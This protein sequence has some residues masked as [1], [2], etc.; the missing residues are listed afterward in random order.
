MMFF[1]ALAHA[2]TLSGFWQRISSLLN[3]F[4]LLMITF[5]LEF[6]WVPSVFLSFETLPNTPF[7]SASYLHCREKVEVQS[8]Q[9]PP[10][11]ITGPPD[12]GLDDCEMISGGRRLQAPK[13]LSTTFFFSFGAKP[14]K[15]LPIPLSR[16]DTVLRHYPAMASFAWQNNK[17]VLSAPPKTLSP[18]LNWCLCT[19]AKFQL[20]DQ[21]WVHCG[22]QLFLFWC[23][24]QWDGIQNLP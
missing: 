20:R 14:I 11:T 8:P 15:P 23:N 22:I 3:C 18:R 2:L 12:S 5:Q 24:V 19:E 10:E 16:E 13:C 1:P 7:P 4:L 6:Y 9:R 21:P 17:A